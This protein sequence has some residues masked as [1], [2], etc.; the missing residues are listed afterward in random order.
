[1]HY[2]RYQP[3]AI[4]QYEPLPLSAVSRSDQSKGIGEPI[5]YGAQKSHSVLQLIGELLPMHYH[6]Y[7]PMAI[8]QYEPEPPQEC[9]N[10][11]RA[12]RRRPAASAGRPRHTR[13]GRDRPAMRNPEGVRDQFMVAW[14]DYE[15]PQEC[16]NCRRAI[17]RRPA[18][19]AGRPRHTRSGRDR[20]RRCRRQR[21]LDRRQQRHPSAVP[22]GPVALAARRKG[23]AGGSNPN[24]LRWRR[25]G[26]GGNGG[27]G[28]NGGSIGDNSGIRRRF[29][30]GRWR[31][32]RGGIPG[33]RRPRRCRPGRLR[34]VNT[35]GVA[36]AKR[37]EPANIPTTY[38]ATDC[39]DARRVLGADPGQPAP[40]TVPARAA[41]GSEYA[42][43]GGRQ[44]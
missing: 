3:M 14:I 36:V 28:G 19:S 27:A 23:G 20:Q 29:R 9:P 24:G 11:R 4:G 37:N 34:G 1:M 18:A 39:R 25:P 21:G 32:R 31:W 42:W 5:G 22:V 8:G 17:R 7:Q 44:T 26:K 30:W 16:P 2:H 13:S 33:N 40:S 12:I 38:H 10:C 35:P 6:R 43:R 41:A 15:P